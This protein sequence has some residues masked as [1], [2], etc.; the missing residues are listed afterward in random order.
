MALKS[1]VTAALLAATS[2]SGL[3]APLAAK[4]TLV[5]DFVAEPASLDPH[6]QWDVASYTVYRNIFDNM[7]TRD[8]TGAIQPQ[9]ATAWTYLSDTEVEFKIRDDVSFHDGVKLTA[10]DVAFSVNR[11]IS[12]DYASPQ[13]GQFN[14]IEKAEA[15]D[16]TTVVLTT[17]GPYP[18]LMAQLTKLSIVPEH[19]AGKVTKEEFNLNPVGSGPYKFSK[20][21]R[22]VEVLVARNDDYWGEKGQFP[23]ASFRSVPD[24]ATRIANIQAGVTDI[25]ANFDNDL[26]DQL[27]AS[28]EGKVLPVL[29]ERLAFFALNPAVA[30]LD[31]LRIRQAIAHA[32]DK[33]GIVEGILGGYDAVLNQMTTP[34]SFGY[35]EGITAPEYD[36]EKARALVAE[37]GDKAK[38]P[39]KLLTTPTYDPRVVQAIQQMLAEVGLTAQ[40]ESGDMANW[41]KLMQ[42]DR[43]TT[44]GTAFGRW[45][46]GCQDA[47]GVL[48]SLLNSKSPWASAENAEMDA[49][50]EEARV[51]IDQDK[52]LELYKRVHEI[53]AEELYMIPLYQASVI[54]GAAKNIDFKPLPNENLFLN[55]V[56]MTE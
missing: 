23:Q 12:P 9:I 24:G 13:N 14:Q 50:L 54:Y 51:T 43:Q 46:C 40:I 17:K 42:S 29:G 22:G 7:L 56:R 45:S 20:W 32:I 27:E 21:T 30:P 5:V 28:G 49:L 15:K 55:R 47:D 2:L 26:A 11:M 41:M 6:G 10:K 18:V 8:E 3:A 44:P 39:F 38:T 4:E 19:V 53:N 35:V 25:A 1:W 52:R 33:E 48:Y 36:V 31:D 37:V 16:D 34:V